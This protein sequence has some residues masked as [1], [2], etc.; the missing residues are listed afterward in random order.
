MSGS[1]PLLDQV[2]L[3]EDLRKLEPKKLRQLSDELRDETIA[4]AAETGGH[5]GAGLGV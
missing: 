5:F 1:T 2:K 3:P 4:A